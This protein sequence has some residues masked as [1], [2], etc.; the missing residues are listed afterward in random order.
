MKLTH[1]YLNCAGCYFHQRA[2]AVS[3]SLQL[4]QSCTA[5]GGSGGP[6]RGQCT[7][8]LAGL[9]RPN[10]A[11]KGIAAPYQ[12]YRWTFCVQ[13]SLEQKSLTSFRSPVKAPSRRYLRGPDGHL[14]WNGGPWSLGP[15]SEDDERS[16]LVSGERIEMQS[17]IPNRHFLHFQ[18]ELQSKGVFIQKAYLHFILRKHKKKPSKMFRSPFHKLV[19]KKLLA[20]GLLSMSGRRVT[21]KVKVPRKIQKAALGKCPIS[22]VLIH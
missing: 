3:S 21:V 4:L 9:L 14:D 17:L 12:N 2:G 18:Q 16:P 6:V 8:G 22:V 15:I 13:H 1:I 20:T 19:T 10:R 5:A 7:P 11:S